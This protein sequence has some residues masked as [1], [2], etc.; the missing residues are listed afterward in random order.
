MAWDLD[1]QK[2]S[3]RHF[4][5]DAT[6]W[7]LA[8]PAAGFVA[9]C[10]KARGSGDLAGDLPGEVPVA[11][12]PDVPQSDPGSDVPV[13]QPRTLS[14]ARFLALSALVDALIP[15]DGTPG[16]A[17]A[18]AA[19]YVDGMLG[20]FA[21]GVPRIF[22]G[23]PYSGRHGGLDGFSTFVPLTRVEELAWRI[24]IEGT[25][26]VA[27]RQFARLD[28]GGIFDA[29]GELPGFLAKY[30]T[31]LDDL[32]AQAVAQ[33]Y[34]NFADMP[35]ADRRALL[36]SGDASM[37]V[38]MAFEHAVEGTYG[39]PVYGGNRDLVGWKAID[40][41]GDRQPVGYTARQMSN[42]EALGPEGL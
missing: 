30:E 32:D 24:R 20:A 25:K 33:G 36:Q 17:A 8:V 39:D 29:V 38:R 2:V 37:D 11:D 1:H 4:L 41:E 19:D 35:V 13:T 40:Y 34:A 16:A 22:A 31:G 28:V 15:D 14:P 42:P 21:S 7:L 23:G 26:G 9:A 6:G 18:V 27:E 5:L 3:R 10:T 12:V